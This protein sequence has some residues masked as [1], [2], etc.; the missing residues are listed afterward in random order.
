MDLG[1][2]F[3]AVL[4]VAVDRD[5]LHGAGA[6]EGVGGDEVFE[7]VGLHFHEQVLHAAG[8]KLEHALGFA[9]AEEGEDVF[10]GEVDFF[11]VDRRSAFG[12]L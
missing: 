6:I 4:A 2:G 12:L 5:Q 11:D 9:A 7:A 8:F 1:D 3:A 10:V